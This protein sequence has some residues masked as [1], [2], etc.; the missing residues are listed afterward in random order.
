MGNCIRKNNTEKN[1]PLYLDK[2]VYE[3]KKKQPITLND[4][5]L[6]MNQDPHVI[7]ILSKIT[8]AIQKIRATQIDKRIL[9]ISLPDYL[10]A[11]TKP[12]FKLDGFLGEARIVVQDSIQWTYESLLAFL[13]KDLLQYYSDHNL[14]MYSWPYL[15]RRMFLTYAYIHNAFKLTFNHEQQERLFIFVITV[16]MGSLFPTQ[17]STLYI[18]QLSLPTILLV[19]R[20]HLDIPCLKLPQKLYTT[21][22]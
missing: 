22:C 12:I 18:I 1:W 3:Y 15:V 6:R 8:H 9:M 4:T 10:F 13:Q 16:V 7:K 14:D 20:K 19:F 11:L 17:T 5:I 2:Y 21:C